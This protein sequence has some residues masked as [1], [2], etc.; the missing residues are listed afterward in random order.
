[1]LLL[2]P[3]LLLLPYAQTMLS[4]ISLGLWLGISGVSFTFGIQYVEHFISPLRK[5]L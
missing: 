3:A 1:M 5:A 4:L 2:I